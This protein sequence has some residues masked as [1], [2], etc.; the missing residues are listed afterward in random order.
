LC[1]IEGHIKI[2]RGGGYCR[3]ENGT[4]ERQPARARGEYGK[5]PK[6]TEILPKTTNEYKN[7]N[8]VVDLGIETDC[9]LNFSEHLPI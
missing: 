8:N 5:L 6:T 1:V 2:Y 7:N 4:T 9:E 3:V